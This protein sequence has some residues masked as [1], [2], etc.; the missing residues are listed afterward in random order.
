MPAG[1]IKIKSV[2]DHKSLHNRCLSFQYI[3]NA[4]HLQRIRGRATYRLNTSLTPSHREQT[5]EEADLHTF[6]QTGD[7]TRQKPR[8]KFSQR[9]YR[10]C[11][12][13]YNKYRNKARGRR[14][15]QKGLHGLY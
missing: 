10:C 4:W 2:F 11:E 8:L 3:Y 5:A 6:P 14:R 9:S 7:V 1:K 15:K 13:K 12:F